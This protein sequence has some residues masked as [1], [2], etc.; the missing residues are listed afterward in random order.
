MADQNV[1]A[2]APAAVGPATQAIVT[3]LSNL[4]AQLQQLQEDNA[5]LSTRLVALRQANQGG[6]AGG[7]QASQQG[8][9]ATQ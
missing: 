1:G 2:D 3:Q 8:G 4:Q 5:T 9:Q 7:G 6:G